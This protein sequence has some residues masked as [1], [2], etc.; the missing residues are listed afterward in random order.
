MTVGSL[1][2]D[3][4]A[5]ELAIVARVGA[6]PSLLRNSSLPTLFSLSQPRAATATGKPV[7]AAFAV[8]DMLRSAIE[9]L[10]DGPQGEAARVLF[11]LAPDALDLRLQDRRDRAGLLLESQA[12][13]PWDSFRKGPEK[14]LLQRV[15]EEL[16]RL[17]I[18]QSEEAGGP[19]AHTSRTYHRKGAEWEGPFGP[20]PHE[21]ASPTFRE[22]RRSA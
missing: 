22:R 8:V 3:T 20:V 19:S 6:K 7:D 13:R 5:R 9:E 4:L 11:A 21:P 16:Y 15:A 17:E 10:G 14:R 1:D 2:P 12:R 18:L